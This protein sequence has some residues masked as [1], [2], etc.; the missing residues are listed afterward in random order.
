MYLFLHI[1]IFES[2][3]KPNLNVNIINYKMADPKCGFSKKNIKKN[4]FLKH[5]LSL[6]LTGC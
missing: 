2:F 6:F 3:D 4:I 1:F 5:L